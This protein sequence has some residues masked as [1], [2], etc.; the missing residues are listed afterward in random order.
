VQVATSWSFFLMMLASG[1]GVGLPLGIPPLPEDAVLAKVAPEECLL[2]FSSAGM[3]KPDPKSTNQTEKLFAEPEV[4]RLAAEAEKLIRTS[5]KDSAKKDRPEAQALAEDGPTL[6]KALLTRP[7]ALYVAQVKPVPGEPPEL[8]AGAVVS[9]GEDADKLKAALERV[10]SA[11][12]PGKAREVT[13]EGTTFYQVTPHQGGPEI[14]WGVKGQYLYVATGEGEIQ[15]LLKKGGGSAPAWLTDLRKGLPVERV[16]TVGMVHVK[17]LVELLPQFGAPMQA[18][19]ALEALGVTG[20]ERLEGVSGLDKEGFFSR[21]RVALRGEPQGLLRLADQKPLTAA[22]LDVIPRDATFAVAFRLDPEK[23]RTTIF[24]VIDKISPP[25]RDGPAAKATEI[26]RELLDQFLKPLGDTWCVF[27]SPAEGGLFTGVT[28]VVSLKD[29]EAA[30]AAE[31][32]FLQMIESVRANAPDAGRAPRVEKFA[33]ARHTVYVFDPGEKDFPLAPSWCLTDKHLVVAAYPEALKGFLSRGKAF[34][35]LAKV[36]EV[37]AAL[38]GE[39]H[40]VAL[41]F[42]D[43]RRIFDI[44]YPFLPVIA[45]GLVTEWRREGI[46]IPA[47]LLPSARSI[48][49]HLRPSVTAVRRTPA[50]VEFVSRQTLP[51]NMGASTLPIAAGL[52]VPAVQKVREAAAR[53]QSSN[54]LRQIGIAMQT[55]LTDKGTF[56]P[57]YS[58]S[59][60]GR[61]LLSWRVHILPYIEAGALYNEFHLNEPWD[62]P[63]NKKLIEKMPKIYRSPASTAAPGMTNYL[64]VRG[65]HTVFPGDRG[66]GV[67]DITDGL[68]N[69]IMVVE[70]SDKKAVPWTKPD[71][72]EFNEKNPIDGLVGLWAQGF[73]AAMCDGSVRMIHTTDAKVLRDLFIRDDGNPLPQDY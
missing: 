55:Y 59:K 50:G 54:N 12:V 64:T 24:D 1:G 3:A 67:A 28:A 2:Y 69:T 35:S 34:Q 44:A 14:T 18:A 13:V 29:H 68:S 71:D 19:Q 45:H 72:F 41:S 33:F 36:P 23:A 32:K 51:G 48:R 31:K 43:T 4:R 8:R 47:G 63:H 11:A 52:L 20:I 60:G 40:T 56:P 57:A 37:A 15:A 5:L 62:S 61:Q 66:V 46:D 26:Q 10:V 17:A 53:T 22:D 21:S 39:G 58:V 42:A 6:V 25:A 70:A 65:E 9:L 16:S 73:L 38:E 27:D 30:V 49:A 7:L